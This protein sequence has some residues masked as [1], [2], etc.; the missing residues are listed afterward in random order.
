MTSSD[1]FRI[2][3][4][5]RGENSPQNHTVAGSGLEPGVSPDLSSCGF[6]W[7]WFHFWCL[8]LIEHNEFIDNPQG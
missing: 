8:F 3:G 4:T 5:E 7:V 6:V 2:Q 1:N